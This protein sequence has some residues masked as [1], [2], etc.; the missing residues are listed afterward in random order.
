MPIPQVPD[1]VMPLRARGGLVVARTQGSPE[2]EM[3]AI[4]RALG[5]INGEIVV[6]ETRTMDKIIS[7]SLAAQRFSMILLGIFAALALAL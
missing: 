5:K 6:Y 2:T 4:R 1:Q 3:G 7:D